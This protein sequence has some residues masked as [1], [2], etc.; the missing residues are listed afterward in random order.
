M[1]IMEFPGGGGGMQNMKPSL[2]GVCIFSG[3]TQ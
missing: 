3:T 1:K 2:R